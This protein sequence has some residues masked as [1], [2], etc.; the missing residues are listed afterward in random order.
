M[1]DEDT[2]RFFMNYGPYILLVL[3]IGFVAGFAWLLRWIIHGNTS[4]K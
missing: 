2:F 3:M 1:N 4:R